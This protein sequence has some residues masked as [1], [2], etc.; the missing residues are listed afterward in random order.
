MKKIGLLQPGRLGDI[1]ICLPIAK[2]YYNR[3]Y[4]V[5][6]PIFKNYYKMVSDV[7]DYVDFFPVTNNVYECVKEASQIFKDNNITDIIDIAATFPDSTCT[8]EYVNCGDGLGDEAFDQFK[9]RK[10]NVPFDEKWK[11]DYKRNLQ[12]EQNVYNAVVKHT[13]YDIV[14]LEYSGGKLNVKVESRNNIVNFTSEHSLFDWRLVFEQADN[15]V[16]AN[17]AMANFIE[18][19]NLVNKK[20]LVNKTNRILFTH[21]NNWVIKNV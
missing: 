13:P 4:K 14:G 15:I 16:L 2:Y 12:S 5:F 1:I 3:G 10:A 19:I 17:S 9:Y 7:V 6:W 21:K 20:Y 18:Q 8:D 11:L